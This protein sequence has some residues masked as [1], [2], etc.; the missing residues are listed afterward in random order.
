METKGGQRIRVFIW[1][2]LHDRIMSNVNDLRGTLRMILDASS[3]IAMTIPFFI[4]FVI[5]LWLGTYGTKSGA[6]LALEAC[7]GLFVT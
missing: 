3:V 6:L 1:L 5:V 4:Y 7:N 2:V